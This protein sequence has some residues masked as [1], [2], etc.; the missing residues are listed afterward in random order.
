MEHRTILSNSD[1]TESI[2]LEED[3][4]ARNNGAVETSVCA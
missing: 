1:E 4:I 3:G 2:E